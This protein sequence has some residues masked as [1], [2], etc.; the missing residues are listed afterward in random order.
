MLFLRHGRTNVFVWRK[1]FQEPINKI[2]EYTTRR[3]IAAVTKV[4]LSL[5]VLLAASPFC[6]ASS[7]LTGRVYL[8]GCSAD[9]Q[10]G[11]DYLFGDGRRPFAIF[12]LGFNEPGD[13][14]L[15][16]LERGRTYKSTLPLTLDGPRPENF[17]GDGG[18]GGA[19][20]SF[21]NGKPR[22][23]SVVY[24]G[25]MLFNIPR[26]P[27]PDVSV[28]EL[29]LSGLPLEYILHLRAWETWDDFFYGGRSIFELRARGRA[30]ARSLNFYGYRDPESGRWLYD[31]VRGEVDLLASVPEPATL[32]L[33]A[34]G[35]LAFVALTAAAR[36]R[37]SA[38][39]AT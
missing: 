8:L 34:A 18:I 33:T 25:A 26:L 38:R 9:F 30:R 32:A 37:S 2:A 39:T 11:S 19:S 12:G 3:R 27:I 1:G 20:F 24:F 5:L 13:C 6:D 4:L 17:L 31:F 29:S 14:H 15:S 21:F 22:G 16:A 7:I 35:L 10:A 23:D 36:R 28:P